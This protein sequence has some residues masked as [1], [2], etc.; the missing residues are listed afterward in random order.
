VHRIWTIRT[1][2]LAIQGASLALKGL[3]LTVTIARG[4][5]I[6]TPAPRPLSFRRRWLPLAGAVL[7]LASLGAA[8]ASAVVTYPTNAPMILQ[9][10]SIGDILDNRGNICHSTFTHVIKNF[11]DV[12][13]TRNY[14]NAAEA[15]GLKVIAYFSATVNSSLGIVYPARVPYW[16][17]LV[18]N[19]PNLWGY[20]TVKEPSWTRISASEIRTMYRAFKAADPSHPVMA[21]FGDV[22]HFGMS[23]NPYTAG[24]ADV[25]M[26]DWYP[27]ETAYGGRSRTGTSYVTTGPTNFKRI[28]SYVALRTPGTPIWLMVGTHRNLN[29]AYHKKQRPTQALLYR[30]VREG[31]VYLKATGIAFHTWQNTAYQLDQRRD[32]TMVGWMRGLA[33]K[34][35]AGTFQ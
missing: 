20:L 32:P 9:N 27:V 17:N 28:R 1:L 2:Q 25:V 26:L 14:L 4:I 35:Q 33:A 29:P 5:M 8:P 12:T 10:I 3:I 11:S 15:C 18:K 23:A 19:H 13:N 16:V 22:P 31:F 21:L 24:M 30:Q 6:T 34:V 7:I